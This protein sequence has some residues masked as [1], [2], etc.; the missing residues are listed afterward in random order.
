MP[1]HEGFTLG[2]REN[3]KYIVDLEAAELMSLF[4]MTPFRYRSC[5]DAAERVAS[6][7]KSRMTVS[8]MCNIMIKNP[9]TFQ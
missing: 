1:A 6:Y 5:P 8:V 3:I 2:C 7:G 9:N 4:E